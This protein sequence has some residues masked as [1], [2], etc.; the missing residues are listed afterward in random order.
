M[1]DAFESAAEQI[2][3]RASSLMVLMTEHGLRLAADTD[4]LPETALLPA[5]SRVVRDEGILY[6]DLMYGA[7]GT[8][9]GGGRS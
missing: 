5:G 2:V 4:L 6:I 8:G 7:E 1:Y 9:K 3:G